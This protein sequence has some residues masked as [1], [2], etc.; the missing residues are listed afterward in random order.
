M[1]CHL[2]SSSFPL[3]PKPVCSCTWLIRSSHLTLLYT[4]CSFDWCSWFSFPEEAA[5]HVFLLFEGHS[6]L[7]LF[8]LPFVLIGCLSFTFFLSTESSRLSWKMNGDSSYMCV[9]KGTLYNI[10]YKH[11]CTV[12]LIQLVKCTCHMYKNVM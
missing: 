8:G 6:L 5:V 3:Q 11:A 10:I 12:K 7:E 9:K 2:F 1:F 4:L